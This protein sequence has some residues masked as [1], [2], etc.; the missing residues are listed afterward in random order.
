MKVQ[1]KI[2]IDATQEEETRV[3]VLNNGIIDDYEFEVTAKKELKGNIYLAKVTKVEASLQA[4]FVDYGEKK[5]GFLPF[6]EISIHHFNLSKDELDSIKQKQQEHKELIKS[7]FLAKKKLKQNQQVQKPQ[8]QNEEVSYDNSDDTEKLLLEDNINKDEIDNN[9]ILSDLV[10][11]YSAKEDIIVEQEDIEEDFFDEEELMMEVE[12]ENLTYG[13]RFGY[14]IQDVIKNNQ[15]ILVQVVKE[16]RGNKGAS[17]TT[18]IS[19]PG[20]YCVLMPNS[21]FEGGISK[22]ITNSSDRQRLKKIISSLNIPS[23]T[24]I[25]M[26]TA[27]LDKSDEQIIQDYTYVSKVW[28]LIQKQASST[29]KPGLLF[30]DGSLIKKVVRDIYSEDIDEI[31]I[32]GKRA[33]E[34]AVEYS[35]LIA[36]DMVKKIVRFHHPKFSIFKYNGIEDDIKNIYSPIVFLK[37]G[38]YIVINPTEALV[39]IDVNSGKFKGKKNVEETAIRTNLDAVTE[40]MKQIKLRDIGGLIVV[41]FIDM[42]NPKN[43]IMIEKKLKELAKLDKAKLQINPISSFGLLEI[44]RQRIKSSLMERSFHVCPK[45]QGLGYVRPLELNALN[46]LKNIES[47]VANNRISPNSDSIIIKIPTDESFYLLNNKRLE[48]NK[49]ENQLRVNIRVECDD[50]LSYPFYA[51]E[52]A[53]MEEEEEIISFLDREIENNNKSN[54]NN[55]R[56]NKKHNGSKNYNQNNKNNKKNQNNKIGWVKKLFNFG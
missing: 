26:R 46:I 10:S 42:E 50:T 47:D 6:S 2:L 12:Q 31:S 34:N 55:F 48:L 53:K 17:L 45:C 38:G 28:G 56:N 27:C 13:S 43:R 39:A 29:K 14:K 52:D 16:E 4:A 22:K 3:V 15:Y 11:E 24:N 32:D 40:I 35:K 49:I 21:N 20:R 30:E 9:P 44:S 25:I 19:I 18:H 51:I 41:D 23:N 5:Q 7:N 1:N 33:Y 37:S 54:N 36:P 8:Y